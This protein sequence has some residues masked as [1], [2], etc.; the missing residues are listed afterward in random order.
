MSHTADKKFEAR[1]AALTAWAADVAAR[2][3]IPPSPNDLTIIAREKRVDAAG[4]DADLT[5]A[6]QAAIREVIKQVAFNIADPHRQL[7]PEFDE[8][9]GDAGRPGQTSVEPDRTQNP[10]RHAGAPQT[11][12]ER[13]LQAL[14]AWRDKE[15]SSGRPLISS[16]KESKLKLVV[17]SKRT[18]V[19]EIQKLMPGAGRFAE[20]I[21]QILSTLGSPPQEAPE[22]STESAA[23]TPPATVAVAQSTGSPAGDPDAGFVAGEIYQQSFALFEYGPS[24][25]QAGAI[26]IGK[27]A[28]GSRRYSWSP[29]VTSCPVAIYRVVSGED[30][31]PY[32]PDQAEVVAITSLTAA[33]DDRPARS[34][35]RYVQVWVNQGATSAEA[36]AAQPVLHAEGAFV[37]DV[38]NVEIREDEGRV[39]GQWTALPGTRNV[40]VFRLPAEKAAYSSGDPQYRIQ[41]LTNNLGGFVDGEAERGREYLYQVYAEAVVNGVAR[42]S[43]PVVRPLRVSAVLKP[44]TDLTAVEHGS[45]LD[46][47]CF[48]LQWA[49][50][51]GGTVVIHRNA[52]PPEA[53]VELEPRSTAT[54]AQHGLGEES[55]LAHPI[56]VDGSR[57]LME[58]VPRPA[59]WTRAY[60]TPVTILDDMAHVGITISKSWRDP[61]RNPKILERVNSQILTFEWPDGAAAVLVYV[62]KPGLEPEYAMAGHPYEVTEPDYHQRGGMHFASTLPWEGCDLHLVPVSFE[63]GKRIAGAPTTISYSKILRLRYQVTTK[64]NLLGGLSGLAVGVEPIN[65]TPSMPSFVL[66]YNPKRLPLTISDGV[67]LSMM[68]DLDGGPA[69]ARRFTPRPEGMG[70]WKTEPESWQQTVE[71]DG[72]YIRLFADLPPDVLRTVALLDPPMKTLRISGAGSLNPFRGMFDAR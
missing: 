35:V 8:P 65:P 14:K 53:G 13:A 2:G 46:V 29:V 68:S 40:Q 36:V 43:S 66:V 32:S 54:L 58:G 9:E 1:L 21:A 5:G 64:K 16:V 15:S 41:T 23:L 25:S 17:Q 61:V 28:D 60:F 70:L 37:S 6:W 27:T 52:L 72:G 39:I 10:L 42:L 7:G 49:I 24:S 69:P 11:Y 71:P 62:G 67:P 59:G 44:V 30:H 45:E 55:R 26:V 47:P 20:E 38:Q 4:V 57:A 12:D 18:S 3:F 48:D 33:T 63:A 22:Y 56:V 19:E 34:A 31:P 50:P 51:P